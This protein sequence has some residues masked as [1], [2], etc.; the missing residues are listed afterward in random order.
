MPISYSWS[1]FRQNQRVNEHNPAKQSQNVAQK[2]SSFT[3]LSHYWCWV[4]FFSRTL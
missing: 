2:F 1:N 4:I 3:E